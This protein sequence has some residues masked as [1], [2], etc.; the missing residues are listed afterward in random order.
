MVK[1]T[2]R[3]KKTKMRDK[4]SKMKYFKRTSKKDKGRKRKKSNRKKQI[5]GSHLV[6]AAG[7]GALGA[8]GKML[9]DRILPEDRRSIS[10]NDGYDNDIWVRS[11]RVVELIFIPEHNRD[12]PPKWGDRPIRFL[13]DIKVNGKNLTGKNLDIGTIIFHDVNRGKPIRDPIFGP[14]NITP[15]TPGYS[16]MMKPKPFPEGIMEKVFVGYLANQENI[17]IETYEKFRVLLINTHSTVTSK[18]VHISIRRVRPD[19]EQIALLQAELDTILKKEGEHGDDTDTETDT[20]TGTEIP[21]LEPEPEPEPEPNIYNEEEHI[22]ITSGKFADLR[23]LPAFQQAYGYSRHTPRPFSQNADDKDEEYLHDVTGTVPKEAARI[24]RG[25]NDYRRGG[26]RKELSDN[27][28]EQDLPITKWL[29][30]RVEH[31]YNVYGQANYEYFKHH[32]LDEFYIHDGCTF[33]NPE[34]DIKIVREVLNKEAKQGSNVYLHINPTVTSLHGGTFRIEGN[35]HLLLTQ[36]HGLNSMSPETR[37]M[38]EAILRLMKMYLDN[39]NHNILF[40]RRGCM[41]FYGS[42]FFY[43]LVLL[44]AL[45][46]VHKTP[47]QGSELGEETQRPM[48]HIRIMNLLMNNFTDVRKTGGSEIKLS[49]I[50]NKVAEK[51]VM[52]DNK[53]KLWKEILLKVLEFYNPGDNVDDIS[54]FA[55]SIPNFGVTILYTNDSDENKYLHLPLNEILMNEDGVIHLSQILDYLKPLTDLGHKLFLK[56]SPLRFHGTVKQQTDKY[57][58]CF[59]N[60]FQDE[61]ERDQIRGFLSDYP[62][63]VDYYLMLVEKGKLTDYLHILMEYGEGSQ[64]LYR[65][66]RDN[67]DEMPVMGEP[68]MFAAAQAHAG[69]AGEAGVQEAKQNPPAVPPRPPS[70][71]TRNLYDLAIEE[72]VSKI[73]ERKQSEG[74]SVSSSSEGQQESEEVSVPSSHDP[75]HDEPLLPPQKLPMPVPETEPEPEI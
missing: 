69:T 46:T 41:S 49:H 8:V 33:F 65:N 71:P 24:A 75:E 10:I 62:R 60:Y 14:I 25:R 22:D 5:G 11:G 55:D 64:Q 61:S 17:L 13:M 37:G 40:N 53:Y 23:A 47:P 27:A 59:I 28:Y 39:N 31:E 58:E 36:F 72:L 68:V 67:Y 4:R 48:R 34:T 51:R 66:M 42:H 6:A 12:R 19:P 21:E 30:A 73:Q 63:M 32:C 15:G 70:R 52:L 16:D 45:A 57:K 3:G 44:M 38:Q 50:L 20:D 9:Y 29:D 26:W 18:N 43:S 7:I 35:F 54:F 74:E 2:I 1:K 56:Y